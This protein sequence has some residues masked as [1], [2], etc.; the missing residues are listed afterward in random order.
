MREKKKHVRSLEAIHQRAGYVFVL[1]WAIGLLLFFAGPL[2]SSIWYSFNE[3]S[4][5][6][7]QI[8]TDFIG[9]KN[10]KEILLEDPTYVNELASSLSN[11]LYSIPL[12]IAFSLIIAIILNQRFFGRAFF[13]A[14]YFIP[15][16]F[17]ASS[18]MNILTGNTVHIPLYSEENGSLDYFTV[19][20]AQMN[21][22]SAFMSFISFMLTFSMKVL[23]N[24]AVPIVLFLAG[25][26]EIPASLY[27]VS[28]IEG[29]NKWE[30]FWLVTVPNLR[31]IITLVMIYSMIDLF[32][33]TDNVVV[34]RARNLMDNQKFGTSSAMLWFYFII[35]IAVIGIVYALYYKFCI[36]KWE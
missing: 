12:I 20:F 15:I 3:V 21:L 13:R 29:A 35:V 24:S 31:H 27:E 4:I 30:E 17:T 16:V 33:Q 5:E 6:P 1:P 25:L 23:L 18:V 32:G 19:F 36:K 22:P 8:L 14:V 28:K 9:I 10:F 26:Q 34:E 11:V 7:G 2:F